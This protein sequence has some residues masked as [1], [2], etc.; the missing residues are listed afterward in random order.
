MFYIMTI[1]GEMVDV[2]LTSLSHTKLPQISLILTQA[3]GGC[4]RIIYY[5]AEGIL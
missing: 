3:F 1:Q 4:Q 2:F 5:F